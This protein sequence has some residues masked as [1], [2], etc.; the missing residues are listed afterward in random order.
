MDSGNTHP[1][2]N[3]LTIGEGTTNLPK[4]I[5][6]ED[7]DV[8]IIDNSGDVY[9]LLEKLPSGY[10]G[11]VVHIVEADDENPRITLEDST[12]TTKDYFTV[13]TNLNFLYDQPIDV[14]T[15]V[16]IANSSRL[17][18]TIM[19]PYEVVSFVWSQAEGKWFP[20]R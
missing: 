13:T 3:P 16:D 6:I 4:Y 14:V 20:M 2:N 1:Q 12:S 8:I 18:K 7:A 9:I 10:D 11:K 19:A 15:E 17:I 5:N